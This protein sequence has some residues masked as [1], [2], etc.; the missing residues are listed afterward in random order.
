VLATMRESQPPVQY[1]VGMPKGRLTKLEQQ[2]IDLPRQQARN[3]MQVK[4]LGEDGEL[5]VFVHSDDRVA[6]EC[7][8]RRRQ[9]KWLWKTSPRDRRH[10]DLNDG[11]ATAAHRRRYPLAPTAS[12]NRTSRAVDWFA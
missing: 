1:L 11:N 6:K 3:G 12:C 4:L 9:L 5:Y 8:M 2:L 7:A 10:A